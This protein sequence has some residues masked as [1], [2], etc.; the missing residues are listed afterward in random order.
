MNTVYQRNSRIE[1]A[2][3]E[4]ESILFH[5]ETKQFMKLNGT[6]ALIWNRLEGGATIDEVVATVCRHFRGVSEEQAREDAG[7]ALDEMSKL[8]LVTKLNPATTRENA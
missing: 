4:T 5:P 1:S 3:F 7:A 6:T 2:P 8:G